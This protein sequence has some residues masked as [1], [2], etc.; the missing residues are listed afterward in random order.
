V[1]PCQ[2][3]KYATGG[4]YLFS[5]LWWNNAY[6]SVIEIGIDMY[7]GGTYRAGGSYFS[8]AS[9]AALNVEIDVTLTVR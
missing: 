3:E 8:Q 1:R 7:D 2:S 5:V 4:G 9:Y 6:S